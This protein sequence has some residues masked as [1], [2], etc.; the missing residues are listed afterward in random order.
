MMTIRTYTLNFIFKMF[1]AN[2]PMLTYNSISYSTG[3]SNK[4][5][6]RPSS[7]LRH[8]CIYFSQSSNEN[9]SPCLILN[10]YQRIYVVRK[11]KSH[12]FRIFG[13]ARCRM[14]TFRESTSM[15][16]G[17]KLPQSADLASIARFPVYNYTF[18]FSSSR[19]CAKLFLKVAT[20]KQ[21]R[22]IYGGMLFNHIQCYLRIFIYSI[23]VQQ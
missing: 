20:R 10:R 13:K 19:G 21:M 3:T 22:S 2:S 6:T 8:R 9:V 11:A 12:L 15:Q 5:F 1:T 23:V 17:K 14:F 16:N 7:I 18:A 4:C